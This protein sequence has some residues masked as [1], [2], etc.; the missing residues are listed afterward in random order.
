[1]GVLVQGLGGWNGI[2][3]VCVVSLDFLWRCQM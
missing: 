3:H 1:M 2:M